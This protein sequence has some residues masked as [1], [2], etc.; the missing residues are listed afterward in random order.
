MFLDVRFQRFG[1]KGSILVMTLAVFVMWCTA[2]LSLSTRSNCFI[3]TLLLLL[4][5]LVHH[6]HYHH[7]HYRQRH[8]SDYY[9][10]RI[11]FRTHAFGYRVCVCVCYLV[12]VQ[13]VPSLY[14][15]LNA[16][17]KPVSGFA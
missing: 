3:L 15:T 5:L 12:I 11:R 8:F 2:V 16:L 1:V 9:S 13:L 14:K 4:L 6:C 10:T 7:R 17:S